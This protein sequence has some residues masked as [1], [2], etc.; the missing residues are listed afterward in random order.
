VAKLAPDAALG[1]A[2]GDR[3]AVNEIMPGFPLRLYG[4]SDMT[5][6]GEVGLW[7]GYGEYMEIFPGT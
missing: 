2:E 6:D 7:G 5:G 1:V 3:V 4:Y